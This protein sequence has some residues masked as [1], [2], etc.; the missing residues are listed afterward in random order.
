MS[1]KIILIVDQPITNWLFN[2]F[3]MNFYEDSNINYECWNITNF[4]NSKLFNFYEDL[5]QNK[6]IIYFNNYSELFLKVKN[7]NKNYFYI[8]YNIKKYFIL[9]IIIQ[10]LIKYK[11]SKK[12]YVTNT[13]YPYRKY[14]LKFTELIKI[15]LYKKILF[16][17]IFKVYG[18]LEVKSDYYFSCNEHFKPNSNKFFHIN[19]LVYNDYLSYLKL[20]QKKIINKENN[21]FV[22]IDQMYVDHPD[23]I[24]SKKNFKINPKEYYNQINIFFN[25]INRKYDCR[26]VIALHPRRQKKI[27]ELINFEQVSNKTI[28]LISNSKGIFT[29]DSTSL[30]YA[31]LFKKPIYFIVN[32]N[33]SNSKR[34]KNITFISYLLDRTI[35]NLDKNL[36]I[37]IDKSYAIN[38]IAY[39]NFINKYIKSIYA[40]NVNSWEYIVSE[41]KKINIYK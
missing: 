11:K 21:Y 36:T 10:R 28:S 25:K 41:L 23:W 19:T 15:N 39:T 20:N 40:L 17:I 29:H 35:V 14:K 4:K 38:E 16:K 32:K 30:Q 1:V 34:M 8:N 3:G 18:Y 26:I 27:N 12:I 13:L 2:R 9:D 33:I 31:V 6:K 22:F 24:I 37:A 5:A 7:L